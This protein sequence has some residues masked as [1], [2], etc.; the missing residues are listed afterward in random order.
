M[1]SIAP[2]VTERKNALEALTKSE[3]DYRNL[4]ENHSAVKLLVDPENGNIVKANHAAAKF[5]GWSIEQL[6]TM[7]IGHLNTLPPIELKRALEN[8]LL[9]KQPYFEFKHRLANATIRNVEVFTSISEYEEKR[10]LHSII[11][12]VTEKN[13]I[14]DEL[15]IAKEKAEE[16]ER[17]KSAFLANM[18]HEI[19]TPLNGIL[20]FTSLLT[21]D[22][23]LSKETKL[24][25]AAII[26]KNSEGLLKIISD[27]LDISRLEA[28]KTIMEKK[29]FDVIKM[30]QTIYSVFNKR[31]ADSGRQNIDIKLIVPENHIILNS[32]ENRLTQVISNLL[33]NALKFTSEGNITF[34]IV[35][36]IK[37]QLE[38]FVSDTGI[39]ISK[40]KQHL[41]FDRFSQAED[42]TSRH[43]GGSG[44]GLAI[45]KKL[46]ELMEG[47]ILLE[48]EPGKGSIFRIFLPI[49]LD[50]YIHEEVRQSPKFDFSK[51]ANSILVVEDDPASQRLLSHVLKTHSQDLFLAINGKEALSLAEI[52]KPD[53][54]LMDISLPDSNGLDVVRE[55]RKSDANVYIIAQTAYAMADD[56]QKALE[57][58]CNDFIT[59]PL[60]VDL[61]FQK[62]MQ[63]KEV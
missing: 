12:D 49:K 62:L 32:D 54:I 60:K 63:A 29:P 25:F 17:L 51:Q 26:N 24:E 52:R 53:I 8:A 10:L 38:L 22:E 2:D 35:K 57:A 4:F 45:V 40:E 50:S 11:Q 18:S 33:D 47:E 28:G 59:K 9:K 58:G 42:S 20:G 15:I 41:V 61:L 44:L 37:T 43:Y 36:S 34:G 30:L 55:I 13:R 6:E 23:N 31:L 1:L 19:R 48:S 14:F 46:I 5:Y 56:E 3:Q 39:G 16:S 7:N 21:E 27:I